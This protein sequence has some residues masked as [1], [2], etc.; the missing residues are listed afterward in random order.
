MK[1][2]KQEVVRFLMILTVSCLIFLLH[3]SWDK[4]YKVSTAAFYIS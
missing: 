1:A 3:A 4:P 2:L